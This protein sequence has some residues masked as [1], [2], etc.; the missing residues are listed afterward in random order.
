MYSRCSYAPQVYKNMSNDTLKN[1]FLVWNRRGR[2]RKKKWKGNTD[3][4]VFPRVRQLISEGRLEE[5]KNI[6]PQETYDFLNSKP[7]GEIIEKNYK[8]QFF[9]KIMKRYSAEE[10]LDAR[11]KRGILM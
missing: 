9:S 4:Q 8:E 1:I 7:G 5:V 10:I 6:V 2:I 11:E 3:N